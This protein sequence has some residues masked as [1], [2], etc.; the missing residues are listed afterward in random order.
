VPAAVALSA[1]REALPGT[2]RPRPLLLWVLRSA[3]WE[4]WGIGPG[5]LGPEVRLGV[6]SATPL[7]ARMGTADAPS[8][9][10][11]AP[12]RARPT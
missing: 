4:G 8:G 1:V 6:V 11:R 7:A 9:S 5:R 3:L 12:A 10:N 2:G